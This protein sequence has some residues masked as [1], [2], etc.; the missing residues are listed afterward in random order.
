MSD[1]ISIEHE[2]YGF[3]SESPINSQVFKPR[4]FFIF[5]L[6]ICGN[7]FFH[8]RMLGETDAEIADFAFETAH[9]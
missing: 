1:V 2:R 8:I 9:I 3:C 7:D 4:T 6:P 5:G